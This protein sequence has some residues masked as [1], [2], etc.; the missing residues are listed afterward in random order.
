MP[1]PWL[2]TNVKKENGKRKRKHLLCLHLH[3]L[4]GDVDVPLSGRILPQ[5]V[6]LGHGFGL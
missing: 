1:L 6:P 4:H 2:A 5:Q 3:L